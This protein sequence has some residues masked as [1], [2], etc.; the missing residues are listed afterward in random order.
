MKIFFYKG[1]NK[2]HKTCI[3]FIMEN[4]QGL[5]AAF[6]KKGIVCE[7]KIKIPDFIYATLLFFE[8]IYYNILPIRA[9]TVSNFFF[10][11]AAL[12]DNGRARKGYLNRDF[13]L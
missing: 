12:L 9:M 11:M 13:C 10:L 4:D 5:E 8:K 1:Y 6:L 2:I 7:K 3:G